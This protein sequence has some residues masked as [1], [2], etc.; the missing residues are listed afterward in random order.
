MAKE[1]DKSEQDIAKDKLIEQGITD[2]A[3]LE[4]LTDQY[5]GKGGSYIFDPVTQKRKPA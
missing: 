1:K 4:I 2:P 5:A 3:T